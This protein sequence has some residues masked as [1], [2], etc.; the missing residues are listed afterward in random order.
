M[1]PC[2]NRNNILVYIIER[3]KKQTMKKQTRKKT[4][5]GKRPSPFWF[6]WKKDKPGYH[7]RTVMFDS[8][9]EK[10]FL[11]PP[12]GFPICHRKTCKK[13]PKG[14]MAAYV[15]SRQYHYPAIEKKAWK[16]IVELG[17]HKE[18]HFN[19]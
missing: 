13:S 2:S 5:T 4:R 15:R 7:E 19:R 1:L 17:M 11:E 8:C 14:V 3:M 6:G 12:R 16:E 10:C 18:H 9:G